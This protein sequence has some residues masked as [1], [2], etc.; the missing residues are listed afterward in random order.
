M[1]FNRIVDVAIPGG[2][3][4][5]DRFKAFHTKPLFMYSFF[6][7]KGTWATVMKWNELVFIPQNFPDITPVYVHMLACDKD[8][9]CLKVLWSHRARSQD[10]VLFRTYRHLV[11][12][13]D[14]FLSE[15]AKEVKFDILNN[16]TRSVNDSSIIDND[17][18]NKYEL[19]RSYLYANGSEA[20]NN[21]KVKCL[22]H[23]CMCRSIDTRL[24]LVSED[25]EDSQ[26]DEQ[27][28]E[29]EKK[30]AI[31]IADSEEDPEASSQVCSSITGFGLDETAD[32][33]F[34]NKIAD[35]EM[36][37]ESQ[38]GSQAE[39]QAESQ[40]RVATLLN[41]ITDMEGIADMS[42]ESQAESQGPQAESQAE[43]QGPQG[44]EESQELGQDKV[45]KLAA[46]TQE[47]DD[48][49]V[50]ERHHDSP[51]KPLVDDDIDDLLGD[52]CH[53]DSPQKPLGADDQ[54]PDDP[55]FEHR[56]CDLEEW[57]WF[58]ASTPCTP[59]AGYGKQL[60]LADPIATQFYEFTGLVRHKLPKIVTHEITS[61]KTAQLIQQELG[62]IYDVYSVELC[63]SMFGRPMK[64]P[65]TV[66]WAT[67]KETV[68]NF[69]DPAE[70]LNLV[71][72]SIE[73]TGACFYVFEEERKDETNVM[74]QNQHNFV[75]REQ[76]VKLPMDDLVKRCFHLEG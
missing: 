66:C 59:Y 37:L 31:I 2:Q 11:K 53:A 10:G 6:T 32:A 42:L 35:I 55:D 22:F 12:D 71:S 44:P 20:F 75:T 7:G 18:A 1:I 72:H 65:R 69:T 46:E 52:E 34:F 26:E 48:L 64:R 40:A 41:E 76:A 57:T 16:D 23:G 50:D 63:V 21:V 13:I 25:E 67:H 28:E 9:D 3:A 73:I 74:A 51:E 38:A 17:P 30:L 43:S 8:E 49:L 62:D 54:W 5:V 14:E 36:A 4:R 70:L 45:S 47:V 19:L 15:K 24:D 58:D 33:A 39:S 61:L 27:E 29:Q 60:R 56:L 68:D